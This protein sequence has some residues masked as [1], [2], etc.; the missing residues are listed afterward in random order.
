MTAH[1]TSAFRSSSPRPLLV[2]MTGDPFQPVR[3]YYSIPNKVAATRIF[4]ALRCTVEEGSGAWLWHYEEEA[5]ALKFGR[6]RDELPAEVHPIILG[7][8]RFPSKDRL[9]LEVRSADRA[10][11]AAKF[12]GPMFGPKVVLQRARIINRLFEA[13]EVEVGLDRLDRLLD[14]NV[15]RIDPQD[16][17]DAI[18]AALAGA[19]TQEEKQR[20][21]FAHSEER[22]KKDVP[23]VEDFPLAP[24][25]ETPEF[26]H[27][28]MT[29]RFR[30]LRAYEH[31]KGN[32]L[33]LAEVI[34]RV[35]EDGGRGL[36][37]GP[38]V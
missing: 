11:E 18:E 16:A 5:A 30:G 4:L 14:A 32:T 7:R 12:F 33:T 10:I 9:V 8:F 20:A 29:L 19:R 15:V 23:L 34:H 2:T 27:L 1:T 38:S 6:P 28:T 24:E 25:E 13:S 3:L 31:W 37:I 36:T 35:V 21:Y 17:E 26:Q 22:R